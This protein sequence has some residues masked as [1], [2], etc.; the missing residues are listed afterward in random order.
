[1]FVGIVAAALAAFSWSLSFIAPFVIG[2]YSLFDFTLV[3]FVVW[4]SFPSGCSSAYLKYLGSDCI[5]TRPLRSSCG[6]S[7]WQSSRISAVP[8]LGPLLHN[9]YLLP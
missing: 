2:D 7:V 1:M 6:G 9:D 8:P 5:G 3:E 4:F